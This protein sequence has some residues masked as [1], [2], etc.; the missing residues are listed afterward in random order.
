MKL[1]KIHQDAHETLWRTPDEKFSISMSSR[2]RNADP[3]FGGRKYRVNRYQVIDRTAKVTLGI[4]DSF[5][6]AKSL[7]ESVVGLT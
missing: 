4:T 5:K 7:L 3:G 1:V 6:A 2:Y